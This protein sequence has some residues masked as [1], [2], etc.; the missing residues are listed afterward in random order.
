MRLAG[1]G[2]FVSGLV[3]DSLRPCDLSSTTPYSLARH[4]DTI[5]N[6]RK[7]EYSDVP[8]V[9]GRKENMPQPRFIGLYHRLFWTALAKPQ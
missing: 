8:L 1:N 2:W 4:E 7:N 5:H 9:M 6:W 3:E